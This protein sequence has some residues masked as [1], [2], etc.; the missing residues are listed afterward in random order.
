MTA[1]FA[2][3]SAHSAYVRYHT[4][5]GRRDFQAALG[6]S[7]TSP[8]LAQSAVHHLA[9]A[10]RWG[11]MVVPENDRM[12]AEMHGRAGRWSE[13]ETAY[14]R[15][16]SWNASDTAAIRGLARTFAAQHRFEEAASL[17]RHETKSDDAVA[18]LFYDLAGSLHAQGNVTSAIQ[19]LREAIVHRPDFARAHR[20]LGASLLEVGEAGGAIEHLRRAVA[21]A[22][23]HSEGHYNLAIALWTSGV[24]DDARHEIDA[25]AAL[26][27]NDEQTQRLR[28]LMHGE[29]P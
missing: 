20:D 6:E 12:I 10:N 9:T 19:A 25:A 2:S 3:L 22:P 29:E 11:L 24:H 23:D 15:V 16:L 21:L 8:M 26:D 7:V 5:T 28:N 1:A 18:Q 27:P 4:W 14:R 13:A 17:L